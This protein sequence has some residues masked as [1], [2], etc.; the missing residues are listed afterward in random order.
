MESSYVPRRRCS[1]VSCFFRSGD[2]RLRV[3]TFLAGGSGRD[4]ANYRNCRNRCVGGQAIV[5]HP[6]DAAFPQ[7]P[8]A[9][10]ERDHPDFVVDFDRVSPLLIELSGTGAPGVT[11]VA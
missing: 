2:N 7:M 4:Q 6:A 8:I 3:P 11:S 1:R 10:L 9:A 5:Q